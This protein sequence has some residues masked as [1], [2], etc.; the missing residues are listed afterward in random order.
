L[1]GR[2]SPRRGAPCLGGRRC[3]P[4]SR[5]RQLRLVQQLR[6]ARRRFQ[7]GGATPGERALMER[8][9]SGPDRWLLATTVALVFFG[10]FV[11]F[12]A[13]FVR[14]SQSSGTH[15]NPYFYL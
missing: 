15:Y 12:D 4:R 9:E 1:D 2:R 11:V 3:A 10:V 14:A 7:G 6:A 8:Q 5:V 13:S